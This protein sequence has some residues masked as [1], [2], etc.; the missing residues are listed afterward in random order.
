VSRPRLGRGAPLAGPAR[1][2]AYDPQAHGPG[3]LHIGPGA[4]FRAHQAAVTDAALA[5]G[6]G[7]WRIRAAALRSP[8]AARVLAEQ[9]GRFTLIL[10][11]GG[12]AGDR[13]QVIGAIAETLGPDPEPV[14][15]ALLRPETRLVTLTVTEKGYG[16]D[17]ATGGADPRH[18]AVAADLADPARPRGVLGL[19]A[20]ALRHR[21]AGGGAAPAIL[22]CDNLPANG[23]LLRGAVADFARRT[24]DPRLA[25]RIAAE[26]AFPVS[27]VDRITPAPTARTRADAARL[28]GC[29]DRAAVEAE[30]FL[31]WVIAGEF[32]LGRP[33]WEAGGA[34]VVADAAPFEA[35]KLRMLNG[36]HSLIAYVGG[37]AGHATVGAAMEDPALRAVLEAFWRAMARTLPAAPGRDPAAYAGALAA[38]FANPAIAHAT[39]QIAADGSQKLPQRL[40]APAAEARARGLPFRPIAFAVAAWMHHCATTTPVDPRA[41]E[42]AAAL[43][44]LPRNGAAV[45]GALHRL[46][47]LFPDSLLRDPVWTGTVSGQL[48]RMLGEGMAAALRAEAAAETA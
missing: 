32:P 44:G 41:P 27:M 42:I 2:P 7:D 5:A 22:S 18:A 23:V 35:M 21:W 37:G 12:G 43:A 31:D 15:A 6:G 8:E 36:A 47:G 30:P 34:L 40:L 28:T 46:P 25:D 20:F 1:P 19:L 26:A 11:D 24:G 13:A 3:I 33:A 38:R 45:A 16:I 9:D 29:E 10:R 4:F 39:A 14:R 17:R 48:A